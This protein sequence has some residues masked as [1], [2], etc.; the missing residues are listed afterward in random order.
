MDKCN[1]ARKLRQDATDVERQLWTELRGH[2]FGGLKFRRQQPLGD[3]VVDFVCF[4]TRLVIELDGGQ[5]MEQAGYDQLR[6][7]WLQGQGFRVLHFWN[8]EVIEN[9]EGVLEMIAAS[10]GA[11]PLSPGP[12]PAG[13]EGSDDA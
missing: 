9:R 13:G 6:D 10:C 3:Y 1:F 4:E 7:D 11:Y 5:H 8:N 12:S 2:R